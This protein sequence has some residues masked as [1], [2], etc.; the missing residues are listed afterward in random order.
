MDGCGVIDF[1]RVTAGL[2][3]HQRAA[4][5]PRHEVDLGGLRHRLVDRARDVLALARAPAKE[6]RGDDRE[7]ELLAGD[8]IGVPHLRRDR[9][10][11]VLAAG[12]GS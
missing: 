11:I 3:Q 9:R 5:D 10:Q 8:V 1:A 6:Q 4:H 12:R 2:A 7:R